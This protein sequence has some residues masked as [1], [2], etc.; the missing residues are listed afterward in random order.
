MNIGD[1]IKKRRSQL[2]MTL[3]DVGKLVGVTRATIQRYENGNIINIP[4]DK[5]ELIAKALRTTPS[6][7]MGWE[8]DKKQTNKLLTNE[9]KEI[10]EPYNQLNTEGK[11]K[12]VEYTWDLVASNKYEKT[13]TVEII[14]GAAAGN[15][16]S[17]IDE[18]TANKI[19]PKKQRPAYDMIIPVEG[20]SM[21][22][23]IHDGSLAFIRVSTDYDNGK[24]YVVDADG[25]V[26]I[27]KVY[28]N[29]REIILKS[30]NSSYKD[31][32][33]EDLDTFRV[34]GEVVDW[35]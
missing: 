16:F 14:G 3:D 8:E 23:K 9:E 18:I 27:K 19:I 20:D 24:I 21:E 30:I 25:K 2:N 17:Y 32:H 7:L 13:E 26:Y 5:I 31:I 1:R 28:F 22:P 4:S 35:E 6:Y 15:G 11:N 12:S 29:D 33:I 10:L 34:I